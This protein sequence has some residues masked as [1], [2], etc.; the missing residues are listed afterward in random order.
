M[1]KDDQ[2]IKWFRHLQPNGLV[3]WHLRDPLL[4]SQW[5]W[6]LCGKELEGP[7]VT[8]S[9]RAMESGPPQ[10]ELVNVC[11][12]CSAVARY[13]MRLRPENLRGVERQARRR[14]ATVDQR[15]QAVD[16]DTRQ[17]AGDRVRLHGVL[18]WRGI[19]D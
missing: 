13:V 19:G 11:L 1:A 15:Q 17:R 5:F 10:L 18:V 2:N 12:S 9:T 8:D 6:T 16:D 14:Q 4:P 3:V 7:R